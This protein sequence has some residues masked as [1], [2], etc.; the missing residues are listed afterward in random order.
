MSTRTKLKSAMRSAFEA[1]GI[2][3][4]P[5]SDPLSGDFEGIV[6][7]IVLG[8]TA[9]LKQIRNTSSC[10]CSTS[11]TLTCSLRAPDNN[12]SAAEDLLDAEVHKAFDAFPLLLATLNEAT[13]ESL[14]L[15][16]VNVATDLIEQDNSASTYLAVSLSLSITHPYNIKGNPNA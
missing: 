12:L 8:D 5:A 4:L 6:S 14:E 15:Q 13:G 3:L 1:V 11:M 9:I 10:L 7:D 16:L 2:A